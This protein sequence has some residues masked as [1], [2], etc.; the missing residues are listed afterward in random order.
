MGMEGIHRC[1]SCCPLSR[2]LPLHSSPGPSLSSF[3]S[4]LPTPQVK[5]CPPEFWAGQAT[6]FDLYQWFLFKLSTLLPV[7]TQAVSCQDQLIWQ[8]SRAPSTVMA[9]HSHLALHPSCR[10][11]RAGSKPASALA[12]CVHLGTLVSSSVMVITA[13]HG[14]RQ[15]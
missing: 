10:V 8:V 1:F 3:P 12:C 11:S 5:E 2:A 7:V 14:A 15:P 13:S 6:L 9:P 4:S